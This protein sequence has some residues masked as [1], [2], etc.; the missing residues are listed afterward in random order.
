MAITTNSNNNPV[1]TLL[2]TFIKKKKAE[3]E[4]K[5]K[6]PEARLTAPVE[7]VENYIGQLRKKSRFIAGGEYSDTVYYKEYGENVYAYFT[8][9][10]N[11]KT[12]EESLLFDGYM[13]QEE[14]KLNLEVASAYTIQPYLEKFGYKK[15]FERPITLWQFTAGII[16][17]TANSI[18]DFGD[19]IEISLPATKFLKAREAAETFAFN[20]FEKL[21]VKKDDVIP[22]D[23]NTLQLMQTKQNPQSEETQSQ[24]NV[25]TKTAEKREENSEAK[26]GGK[27]LF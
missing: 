15:A 19:F 7:D 8:V 5:W 10:V 16:G 1:E 3:H 4:L 6:I 21:G 26:L 12:E 17:I 14:D 22:T 27:K 13:I 2:S 25:E 18:D 11:A 23:V 24:G 20:F 9:R